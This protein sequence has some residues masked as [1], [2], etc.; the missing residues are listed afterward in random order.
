[1]VC[2]LDLATTMRALTII[3]ELIFSTFIGLVLIGNALAQSRT[4]SPPTPTS[5]NLICR[6]CV[7]ISTLSYA[8]LAGDLPPVLELL[9]P[10]PVTVYSRPGIL[11]L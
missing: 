2:S 1:M 7:Y 10:L 6:V 4:M 11:N 9:S 3:S 5:G 8:F